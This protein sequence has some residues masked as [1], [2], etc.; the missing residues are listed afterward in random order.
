MT[1]REFRFAVSSLPRKPIINLLAWTVPEALPTSLSGLAVERAV[2][3]GFLAGRPVVGVVWL[4]GLVVAAAIGGIGSRQVFRLLGLVVEP[5]RDELV[6]RVVGGALRRGVRG[7][8]DDGALARLTHQVEI[9]RDNYAGLIVV[10][11]GFAVTVIGVVIG[12]SS[13]APVIALLLLPPFVLGFGAF[14]GTL[15]MASNRYRASVQADE[16]AAIAAGAVLSGIRDVVACGAEAAAER[17]VAGP[18]AAQA[19]AERAV[20]RVAVARSLCFAVGGWLPMVVLLIAGPW[21]VRRGLTAGD[22][23]GGLTYVL[24]GLQPMLRN[25]MA[26]VGSS[27]LRFLVTLRRILDAGDAPS[28]DAPLAV[29][30]TVSGYE[31]AVRNMTFAYG[32]HAEPVLRGLDLVVPEGDHLAIVGPSGIGKS[33]LAGLLCGL[34]RPNAGTVELRGV[35]VAGLTGDRLANLRTLIPQEAY[36]FGASVWDNLRYLNPDVEPAAVHRAIAVV[37]AAA[38]VDRLG[39]LD[40]VVVPGELSAGERQMI[41]LVRAYVSPA[42]VV[43][44]DEATCHLDPVAEARAEESF[45][46]RGGTLIVIAH[47]VSSAL[48]ARR[49]LVLDGSGAAEGD[50]RTLVATSPLYRELLGHWET[51]SPMIGV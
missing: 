10:L 33:T 27:G 50:H 47:R 35:P 45:A 39:G 43:V 29:V 19:A 31:L 36:V 18:V 44:L 48:R 2:D 25:I 12:L 20:A 7:R 51:G 40:G 8:P 15:G 14:L 34:L 16:Q 30:R 41:A 11:R 23:M 21:L 6:R 38:L 42:P 5:F 3:T 49:V 24:I 4:S 32:P 46:E 9:A 17:M 1:S 26:A 28:D 13:I 22:I 37:G